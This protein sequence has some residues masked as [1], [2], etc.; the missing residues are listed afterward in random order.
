MIFNISYPPNGTN[1]KFDINDLSVLNSMYNLRMSG[2]VD[3]EKLGPQ[4]AGYVFKIMGGNDK[5]GFTMKQGVLLNKRTRL[6]LGK[7]HSCYRP[8]RGGER[9][10]KSVR[11]CEVGPDISVLALKVLVKGDNEIAGLT[12]VDIPN[13]L[14]PKRASRIRRL[15]DLGKEDDVRGFTISRKVERNGKVRWKGPKVQRLVTPQRLRRKLKWLKIKKARI[16]N[17]KASMAA[18]KALKTDKKAHAKAI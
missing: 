17:K 5:Q 11:G 14:G 18:Y 13:R 7:G 16:N 2:E 4:F 15:F 6:L 9:K 3:G 1:K 10:R 12:D 8:R